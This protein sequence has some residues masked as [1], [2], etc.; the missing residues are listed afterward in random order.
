MTQFNEI[1]GD[2]IYTIPQLNDMLLRLK[3]RKKRKLIS[4]QRFSN[5][6]WPNGI[7]QYAFDGS[8]SKYSQINRHDTLTISSLITTL[9]K[10]V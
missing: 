7:I 9:Y 8:H 3:S 4:K 6:R 1:F 10:H 5:S 2:I